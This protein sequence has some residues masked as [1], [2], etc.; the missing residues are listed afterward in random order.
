FKQGNFGI[1]LPGATL[2][3]P[4]VI[5]GTDAADDLS[6]NAP[7]QIILAGLGNDIG[8]VTTAGSIFRGGSGNDRGYND[9]GDQYLYGDEGNDILIASDGNDEL[10]GGLDND[11]LQGGADNDYLTGDEGNDFLA[12]GAGDDVLVGGD[13]DDFLIG[14]G[15]YEAQGFGGQVFGEL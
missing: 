13:G 12:G 8:H 7:N 4:I 6:T 1:T 11:A 3:T 10:Y 2:P 14:G 5:S 15:S 9:A